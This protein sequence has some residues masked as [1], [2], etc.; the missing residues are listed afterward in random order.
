MTFNVIKTFCRDC[1]VSERYLK[2][3]LSKTKSWFLHNIA[4]YYHFYFNPILKNKI[5]ICDNVH[6][7]FT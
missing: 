5:I 7:I 2:L 1:T 4:V 3:I 6:S